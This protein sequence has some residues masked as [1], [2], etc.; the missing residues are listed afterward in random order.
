MLDKVYS[1][2]SISAVTN[3]NSSSCLFS[4]VYI[5]D[6]HRV[7]SLFLIFILTA[8]LREMTSSAA[9]ML[10]V[11]IGLGPQKEDS[12]NILCGELARK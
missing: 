12:I 5:L 3:Y 6:A 4:R 11:G 7:I 2:K 9:S 10:A 8:E 1:I